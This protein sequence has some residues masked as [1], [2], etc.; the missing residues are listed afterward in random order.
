MPV[1]SKAGSDLGELRNLDDTLKSVIFGQ[2]QAIEALV[3]AVKRSR[4][5]LGNP[6]SP[7]GSFLFAGPNGRG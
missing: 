7:T 5:G 2:D 1:N 3:K 6:Q 4:A